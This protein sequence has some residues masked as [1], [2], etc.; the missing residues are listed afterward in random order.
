VKQILA[1]DFAPN[2]WQIASGSDDRTVRIWD[3]RKRETSYVI[4]AHGHLITTVTYQPIYGNYIVTSSYDKTC[5][6]WSTKNWAPLKTFASH[7]GKVSHV[8]VSP[9]L[10]GHIQ[11]YEAPQRL[12]TC[13]FDRTWK[14]WDHGKLPEL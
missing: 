12:V 5:R 7:E 9:P 10:D 1:V 8:A 2:G 11:P 3:L 13:S 6:I 4:P 14:V